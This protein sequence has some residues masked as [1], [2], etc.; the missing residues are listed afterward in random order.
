V[1]LRDSVWTPPAV[2]YLGSDPRFVF[3]GDAWGTVYAVDR[4]SGEVVWTRDLFSAIRTL[5]VK[6]GL[7]V[8][9]EGGEVYAL[10]E[11]DGRGRWRRKLGA[12]IEALSCSQ[13]VSVYAGTFGGALRKLGGGLHAGTTRWES[14]SVSAHSALVYTGQT[15]YAND[16]TGVVA[17]N[18]RTGETEWTAGDD[19]FCTP[20]AAGNTLYVGGKKT[21]YAYKLDGGF[22]VDDV[23]FAPTRWTTELDGS[24]HQVTV[25]DGAV[26]ATSDGDGSADGRT[27]IYAVESA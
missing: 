19:L 20:A 18:Y 23:R 3:T 7:F 1:E 10:D 22:G 11:Q 27:A 25:A 2:S 12:A 4:Q 6:G 14:E 13:G 8:G 15:V 16:G 21:L 9:T 26:F 17:A 24:I 5:A